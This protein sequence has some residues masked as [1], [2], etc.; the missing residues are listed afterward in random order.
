VYGNENGP[1][2]GSGTSYFDC[3][4]QEGS[5]EGGAVDEIF[6]YWVGFRDRVMGQSVYTEGAMEG[7]ERG[8]HEAG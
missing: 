4:S 5:R 2:K 3:M 1:R 8:R 6:E 7:K